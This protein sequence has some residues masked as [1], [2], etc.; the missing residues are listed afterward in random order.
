MP[1]D[2]QEAYASAMLETD[3]KKLTV[4]IETAKEVLQFWFSGLASSPEHAPQRQRI[5]D[6]LRTLD[7]VRRIELQASA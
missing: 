6:A 2:W 1:E 3:K 7:M 4:K 5:E